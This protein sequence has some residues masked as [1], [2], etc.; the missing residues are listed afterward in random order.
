[1]LNIV[2]A[3]KAEAAPLIE[4][5]S[6]L[7]RDEN[8]A[9]PIYSGSRVKLG[10]CGLGSDNARELTRLLLNEADPH[11]QIDASH[12]INFG[13]AGSADRKVGDLVQAHCVTD[14]STGQAWEL[15]VRD[16]LQLS[17]AHV[18][19]VRI[20]QLVYQRDRV[21]DMEVA[22]MLSELS[23][24]ELLGRTSSLKLI[25]DGP[26]APADNLTKNEIHQLIQ[27]RK[28]DILTAVK[29]LYPEAS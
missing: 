21:Y 7:R 11:H 2:V 27:N 12:W 20:P 16:T 28:K 6:L 23:G 10:I 13:I 15:G 9:Y 4:G 18:F 26:G 29:V 1:V 14:A 17:A 22:G 3:M 25:S 19:T 8:T 24:R 5:F